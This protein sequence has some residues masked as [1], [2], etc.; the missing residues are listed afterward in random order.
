M[1]LKWSEY[2]VII[3]LRA[4]GNIR[5]CQVISM[6]N[7]NSKTSEKTHQ[8]LLMSRE[9][10]D[11]AAV[12]LCLA[13]FKVSKAVIWNK[14]GILSHVFWKLLLLCQKNRSFHKMRPNWIYCHFLSLVDYLSWHMSFLLWLLL[15]CF[16]ALYLLN[17]VASTVFFIQFLLMWLNC[18]WIL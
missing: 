9:R 4:E 13:D 11:C 5:F 2:A 7:L 10:S 1:A 15:F 14:Q 6:I 3:T 8:H 17:V 18:L 12:I 16:F